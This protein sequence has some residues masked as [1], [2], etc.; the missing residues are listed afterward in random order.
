MISMENFTEITMTVKA[1]TLLNFVYAL[2]IFCSVVSRCSTLTLS[3]AKVA[4]LAYFSKAFAVLDTPLAVDLCNE[5]SVCRFIS[6]QRPSDLFPVGCYVGSLVFARLLFVPLIISA[7]HRVS[8]VFV[9]STVV[10]IFGSQP[11]EI[12]LVERFATGIAVRAKSIAARLAR[13]K[14][15]RCRR[16]ELFALTALFGGNR[17]EGIIKRHGNSSFLCQAGGAREALPGVF[18]QFTGVIIPR[19]GGFR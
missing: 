10:A 12:G 17:I 11:V 19:F 15:F 1:A 8:F 14:V 4:L 9:G 18:V 13:P 3:A 16:L 5:L 7:V 2:D 6:F